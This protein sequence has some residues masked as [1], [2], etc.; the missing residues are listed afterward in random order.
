MAFGRP[1]GQHLAARAVR[2][3]ATMLLPVGVR[4]W[5]RAQQRR[6]GLQWTRVGTLE[7]GDLHRVSPVSPVFGLDRGRTVDRHYIERFLAANAADIH[8]RVL[9][10]MD[11]TYT[12]KFGGERVTCRDVLHSVSGNPRATIV[13]NLTSDDVFPTN[14]FDC[15][16]CTQT[17]QFIYEPRAALRRLR[18]MLKPG[19]VLLLTAHGTSR[20]GRREGVDDWGEYWRFTAQ[21]LRRLFGETFTDEDVRIEVHGNVLA[22]VATLHGLAATELTGP[23]LDYRDPNYEVLLAVRA[24]KAASAGRDVS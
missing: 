17:L 2:A 13:G 11:D 12:R 3:V 8:G 21:S 22:A 18:G 7:L 10:M 14:A 6:Y 15:I 4:D 1:P 19:G 16:I 9:E 20:I 24:A 5:I 23:E